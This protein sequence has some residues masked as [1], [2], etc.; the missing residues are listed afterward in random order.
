MIKNEEDEMSDYF[1][2]SFS[3]GICSMKP[4]FINVFNEF[5]AF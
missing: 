4:S 1:S 5:L 3:G 2:S